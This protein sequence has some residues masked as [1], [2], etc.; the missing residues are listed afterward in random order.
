MLF[1]GRSFPPFDFF[2]GV[3]YVTPAQTLGAVAVVPLELEYSDTDNAYDPATA[4]YTISTAGIYYV[5]GKV[6]TNS[7]DMTATQ[8]FIVHIYKNS[9]SA[10]QKVIENG[11]AATG[12]I[13]RS[14]NISCIISAAAGDTISLRAS[15][16]VAVAVDGTGNDTAMHIVRIA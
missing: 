4:L 14:A 1:R 8:S 15:A 11:T 6:K 9:T 5:I 16:E 3:S 13:F 2:K 7:I 10:A 12:D